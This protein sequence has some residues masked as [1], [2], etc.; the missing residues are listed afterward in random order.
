MDV[1]LDP[2]GDG[3]GGDVQAGLAASDHSNN[4]NHNDNAQSPDCYTAQQ[5]PGHVVD[6]ES[7]DFGNVLCQLDIGVSSSLW[8]PNR[9][10][11]LDMINAESNFVTVGLGDEGLGL[12]HMNTDN[13]PTAIMPDA[14]PFASPRSGTSSGNGKVSD[15]GSLTAKEA[16][17][18]NSE[19][20]L[21]SGVFIRKDETRTKYIGS[22]SVGAT[23]ALCLKDALASQRLPLSADSVGFLIEAGPHLDEVDS[24][25]FTALS[26]R[27]L[28]SET[29]STQSI[30]AYFEN[31]NSFYAIL[32]E[33]SFRSRASLF[34]TPQRPMLTPL[35]YSLFY[36]VVSVGALCKMHDLNDAEET[37]ELSTRMYEQAWPL[38]HEAVGA[39]CETSLQILLLQIVRAVY[40]GKHGVAWVLCGLGLRIAQS[41]GLHRKCPDEIA[42]PGLQLRLR[43]HLWWIL[44]SFD[45]NLSLSQGRP[46]AVDETMYDNEVM[47]ECDEADGAEPNR[48]HLYVWGFSLDTIQNRFCN[49]M[50]SKQTVA[51][52]L[53][54]IAELDQQAMAWRDSLPVSCRPG[55]PI[56]APSELYMHVL[57]IHLQYFN[58]LRSIYWAA[59][60]FTS[61]LNPD[62]LS[63]RIRSSHIL[64]V[65]AARSF[66]K[67]LNDS[68][69]SSGRAKKIFVICFH[70]HNYMAAIATL[71]RSIARNPASFS[72]RSDLEHLRAGKI[73]LERDSS[74]NG[75]GPA[76]SKL[77]HDMLSSAQHL[78]ER[79]WPMQNSLPS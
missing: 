24:L 35:D 64:C 10:M 32:D 49:I 50:K 46:P 33:P 45:A 52:R 19:E 16:R 15:I 68:M 18:G 25:L 70:T 23:L 40:F 53:A 14:A 75:T 3:A 48:R 58:L 37:G 4:A 8:D 78:V 55:H 31:V 1:P 30:N 72:S 60:T 59:M 42:L 27:E 77:F 74:S 54:A 36:L 12:V 76:L 28:P 79:Q 65:D 21:T 20:A 73:H 5:W 63:L 43:S 11:F 7:Q 47:L 29:E 9:T 22:T 51:D 34:Y 62:V 71:Y 41:L 67:S 44:I 38:L 17:S 66:I 26:S 13:A 2:N 69:G 56:L 57:L 61:R 39:S 6:E